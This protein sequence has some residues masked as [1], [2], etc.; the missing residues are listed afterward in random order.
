MSV[1]RKVGGI[2]AIQLVLIVQT[3][4]GFAGVICFVRLLM[5]LSDLLDALQTLCDSGVAIDKTVL[6]QTV[7][8]VVVGGSLKMWVYVT[9]FL[10]Y[11]VASI[12][13]GV[14][15]HLPPKKGQG[16][17]VISKTK[18]FIAVGW[19][20]LCMALAVALWWHFRGLG[21]RAGEVAAMF[22]FVPAVGGLLVF[23][24][25]SKNC[26]QSLATPKSSSPAVE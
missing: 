14:V 10:F 12:G 24:V 25:F 3:V 19:E 4:L 26:E 23:H 21:E 18:A 2:R 6:V 8:A 16:N 20:A 13:G 5:I 11:V 22:A 9:A 17:H 15:V 7:N 1:L